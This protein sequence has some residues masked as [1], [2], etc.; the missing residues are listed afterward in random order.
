LTQILNM[1]IGAEARVVSQVPTG[2][3]RIIVDNYV[4]GVPEPPVGISEVIGCH[5]EVEAAEEEAVAIAAS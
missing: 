5:S 3:V 2:I 4:V 1:S